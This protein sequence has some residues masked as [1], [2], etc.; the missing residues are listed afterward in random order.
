[1]EGLVFILV[2]QGAKDGATTVCWY[3]HVWW[4]L[5]YLAIVMVIKVAKTGAIIRVVLLKLGKARA[6]SHAS[7][8]WC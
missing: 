8:L 2:N 6:L 7:R 1:V 3:G 4:L 5:V